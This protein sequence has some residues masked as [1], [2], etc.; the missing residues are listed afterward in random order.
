MQGNRS[1]NT[2]PELEVR[3]AAHALGLRYG[4]GQRPIPERRR[5]ADLV[6]RRARVAVF[7]DGCFWHGCTVHAS[8]PRQHAEYWAPKL[9]R[10]RE[11]DTETDDLLRAAGWLPLRFWAHEEPTLVAATI[12]VVVRSRQ[13][14]ARAR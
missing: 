10:N 14:V 8:L 5:T 4:V 13:P 3:R 2:K 12:A 11:R 6:F 9:A 7:I 1:R